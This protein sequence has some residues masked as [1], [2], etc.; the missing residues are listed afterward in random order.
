M[1]MMPPAPPPDSTKEIRMNLK[2]L[3]AP[4]GGSDTGGGGCSVKKRGARATVSATPK[5]PRAKK[6]KKATSIPKKQGIKGQN[7]SRGI[8]IPIFVCS[9]TGV[10][11]HCYK[12]GVGGWQSTCCTTSISMY[13][14]PVNTKRKGARIAGRKMSQG[15]FKTVLEKLGSESYNFANTIDLRAHWVKDSTHK[16]VTI[17]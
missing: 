4:S 5:Q 1:H 14:L 12:W 3:Q 15:A 7:Q 17:R 16:F 8:W 6:L 2:D 10:T 9:C 13:P 11:Q